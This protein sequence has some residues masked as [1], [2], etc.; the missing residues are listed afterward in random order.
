MRVLGFRG[1]RRT[2]PAPAARG[3][4]APPEPEAPPQSSGSVAVSAT[5]RQVALSASD[6]VELTIAGGTLV[7]QATTEESEVLPIA[8][9]ITAI[10]WTGPEG[11]TVTLE[12]QSDTP[13]AISERSR[14]ALVG[15]DEPYLVGDLPEMLGTDGQ[16]IAIMYRTSSLNSQFQRLLS[17]YNSSQPVKGLLI[18]VGSGGDNVF[19]AGWD[20]VTSFSHGV[21]SGATPLI[22]TDTWYLFVIKRVPNSQKIYKFAN[23]VEDATR[24]ETAGMATLPDGIDRVY[25][26]RWGQNPTEPGTTG[27]PST[28]T[29]AMALV[30]SGTLP[31]DEDFRTFSVSPVP[32]PH[33]HFAGSGLVAA[34]EMHADGVFECSKTGAPLKHIVTTAEAIAEGEVD[35]EGADEPLGLVTDETT[36]PSFVE[37]EYLD[38][39]TTPPSGSAISLPAH[40]GWLRIA[41]P[42]RDGSVI[43]ASID[44]RAGSTVLKSFVLN[45]DTSYLRVPTDTDNLV[46]SQPINAVPVRTT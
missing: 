44:A 30:F 14:I 32:D 37:D 29:V 1:D 38:F 25:L 3:G 13:I 42:T 34:Y 27:I 36:L 46:A 4:S 18:S 7:Y 21:F 35:P 2:P 17:V 11:A 33:A 12:A 28:A 16:A 19:Q 41:P 22:A 15:A 31:S 40:N 10:D 24:E 39:A 6:D 9:G 20:G 5:S 23:G 8:A 26:G 43:G 45:A